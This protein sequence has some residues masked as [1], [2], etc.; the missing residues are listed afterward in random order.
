MSE[1]ALNVMSHNAV[2]LAS[3]YGI[4]RCVDKYE[5]LYGE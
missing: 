3:E 1:K 4:D 5:M 2:M